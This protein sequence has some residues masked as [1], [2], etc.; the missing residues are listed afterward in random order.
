MKTKSYIRIKISKGP[1]QGQEFFVDQFPVTIGRDL[2]NTIVLED[3]ECSREHIKIKSRGQLFILEDQNSKNGVY[4]NGEKVQNTILHNLDLVSIGNCEL[5]IQTPSLHLP[6]SFEENLDFT[7]LFKEIDINTTVTVRKNLGK[8][9]HVYSIRNNII[10]MINRPIKKIKDAQKF[11]DLLGNLSAVESLDDSY[12][13]LLK[14]L[15]LLNPHITK[16]ALF[17]YSLNKT[18]L[19]PS[20]VKLC[21]DHVGVFTIDSKTLA[22]VASTK[23]GLYLIEQTNE[24]T[25]SQIKVVLP[26]VN[27]NLLLGIVHIEFNEKLNNPPL[28]DFETLQYF[29]T[30]SAPHVET[31]QLRNDIDK[32][33]LGM[34]ETIVAT[35][36][37]KDTYT[38][39]HSERVCKFSMAIAQELRLHP[40][41]KKMLM[42]SSLC[43]DIGKIGIP[44]AIL[45]KAS[46][47]SPEEYD[48]MKLHPTIGANII[49]NLPNA[50]KFISGIKYHHEKWDGTG[51]PEGLE[52]EKIPFFGRIVA[53]A[54]VFDAMVSGRAYSG[55]L[56]ESN[57]IEKIEKEAELFDPEIIK[58]LINAW[59]NGSLTQRTSTISKSTK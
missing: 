15:T 51:Y 39:G 46:L 32:L 43:H 44:D 35:I 9:N 40:E 23:Q 52:G 28:D 49:S 55:F 47:L 13:Y 48:E 33:L 8:N 27:H 36:E 17:T 30:R 29:L 50:K 12:S 59:N 22:D 31:L 5:T 56:D 10:Q 42:I 57:A 4:L 24:E 38:V 21:D 2:K 20:A 45:K 1:G 25:C 26:I 58:A 18:K 41:V 37:A 11:Y 3:E 54:D 34:V 19:I 53:V 16:S 6:V 14:S 7:R